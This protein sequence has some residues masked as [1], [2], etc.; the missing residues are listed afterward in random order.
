[1]IRTEARTLNARLA[2]CNLEEL[3]RQVLAKVQRTPAD[4]DERWLLF[5][6]LCIDGEWERALKQ[7]QAW[8]TLDKGSNAIAQLHRNLVRSEVLRAGVLAGHR[9]P[10]FVTPPP[11]WT[12]TLL[13]ANRA[14]GRGEVAQSDELRRI[15]LD[16][17]PSTAGHSPQ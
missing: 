15:A 14:L 6:L 13:E 3:K 2:S 7:L 16:A 11:G 4:S 17:A 12:I 8:A 1:M 5:Q 9:E 10:L